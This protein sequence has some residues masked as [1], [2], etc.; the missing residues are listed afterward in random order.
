MRPITPET[1]TKT[2]KVGGVNLKA[3]MPFAAGDTI[4]ENEANALNQTYLENLGNNFRTKVAKAKEEQKIEGDLSDEQAAS[5]GRALQADFD[6]LVADYKLN[7]RRG[8]S[9]V[10]DPVE[11]EAR[12]IAKGRIT[13]HLKKQG[14]KL[15]TVT[16]EWM[17][18]QIDK[19]LASPKGEAIREAARR[20]VEL[21]RNIATDGL[22]DLDL[23]TPT[24]ATAPQAAPSNP[25]VDGGAPARGRQGPAPGTQQRRPAAAQPQ[26]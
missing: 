15:N 7:V 18:A 11:R 23:G 8:G 10:V 12:D 17:N 9:V 2:I 16:A 19:V 24:A 26:G 22:D 21:T 14:V 1:P 20:R 13:D 5:I 4:D 3:P 25:G 6:K